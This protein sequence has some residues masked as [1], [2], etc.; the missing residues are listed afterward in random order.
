MQKPNNFIDI[1]S[2]L[3]VG[4][5]QAVKAVTKELDQLPDD[6]SEADQKELYEGMEKGDLDGE[7]L[8]IVDDL[9]DIQEKLRR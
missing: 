4:V 9:K 6:M 3:L 1:A 7:M 8:K 5:E 2:G